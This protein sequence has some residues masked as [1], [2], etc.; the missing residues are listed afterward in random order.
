MQPLGKYQFT[1]HGQV[2]NLW[3]I[4]LTKYYFRSFTY[5]I[6]SIR[7]LSRYLNGGH[8]NKFTYLLFIVLSLLYSIAV[9]LVLLY[10]IKL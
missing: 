5:I 7:T 2:Y 1:S 6:H 10:Q 3:S 8:L 9:F 4:C